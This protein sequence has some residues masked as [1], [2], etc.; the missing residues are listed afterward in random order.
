MGT[1]LGWSSSAQVLLPKVAEF[2]VSEQ[3]TQTYSSVFGLGAVFGALTAGKIIKM[4]GRRYGMMLSEIFVMTGW[5]LL[6]LPKDLWMMIGGRVSQGIGIG[7][8]CT[9]IPGY[10]G[11]ISLQKFRG[12]HY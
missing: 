10:V 7:A 3:D 1:I 6:S 11:E 2:T 4:I 5:I 8:L 9:I 12:N